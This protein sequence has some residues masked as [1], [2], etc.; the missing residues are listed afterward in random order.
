MTGALSRQM[1][2]KQQFQRTVQ[3]AY[4]DV[5]LLQYQVSFSGDKYC[6]F[7]NLNIYS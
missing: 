6:C 3:S 7:N 2:I 1:V 4:F 5:Y